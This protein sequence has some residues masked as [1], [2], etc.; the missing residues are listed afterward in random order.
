MEDNPGIWMTCWGWCPWWHFG[1]SPHSLMELSLKFGWNLMSLKASRTLS[2]MDDISVVFPGVDDECGC[3]WLEVTFLIM[4]QNS[5]IWSEEAMF[6][7][8]LR[9][10]GFEDIKNPFKDGWHFWNFCWSW[11]WLWMFL[12]GVGVLD[13]LLYGLHMPLQSY[14]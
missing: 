1:W 14:V 7:I 10:V 4:F 13:D 9:C 2:K 12:T 8:C 6:E 11:W 5:S 3:S